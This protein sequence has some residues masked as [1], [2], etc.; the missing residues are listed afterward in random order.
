MDPIGLDDFKFTL[1]S[2]RTRFLTTNLCGDWSNT[3][4]TQLA[5]LTKIR[6]TICLKRYDKDHINDLKKKMSIEIVT[7]FVRRTHGITSIPDVY[8]SFENGSSSCTAMGDF[9]LRLI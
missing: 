5:T 3:T 7:E 9:L 4:I 2:L 8:K 1:R 6:L